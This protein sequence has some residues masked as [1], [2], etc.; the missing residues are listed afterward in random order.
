MSKSKIEKTPAGCSALWPAYLSGRRGATKIVFFRADLPLLGAKPESN[1]EGGF[2]GAIRML[3]IEQIRG[4]LLFGHRGPIEVRQLHRW[5][6]TEEAKGTFGGGEGEIR[7]RFGEL[8]DPGKPALRRLGILPQHLRTSPLIPPRLASERASTI[9]GFLVTATIR[10]NAWRSRA[11]SRWQPVNSVPAHLVMNLGCL[12]S[13]FDASP[14]F[15]ARRMTCEPAGRGPACPGWRIAELSRRWSR[16]DNLLNLPV[17][18]IHGSSPAQEA[19]DGHELIVFPAPD[20]GSLNPG[21]G[22]GRDPDPGTHGN[23]RLWL[24]RQARAEHRVNLPQV[25]LQ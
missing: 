24:H 23:G 19:D 1:E 15:P 3:G 2:P 7:N 22:P 25:A 5:T 14:G 16:I 6:L 18:E 11:G 12:V 10:P 20:H 13:T 17:L 4:D 8:N 21:K 9:C